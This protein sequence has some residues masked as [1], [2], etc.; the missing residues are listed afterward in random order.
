MGMKRAPTIYRVDRTAPSLVG[1][2]YDMPFRS[3]AQS[4]AFRSGALGQLLKRKAPQWAAKTNFKTLPERVKKK[5]RKKT[6]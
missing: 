3:A 1:V 4:R 5:T 6:K 2:D